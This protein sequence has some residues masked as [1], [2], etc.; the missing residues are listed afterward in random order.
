VLNDFYDVEDDEDEAG[1]RRARKA[2]AN[3]KS[4]GRP[5]KPEPSAKPVKPKGKMGGAR[6]GAGR[7]PSKRKEEARTTTAGGRTA[8]KAGSTGKSQ[9]FEDYYISQDKDLS[10]NGDDDDDDD[11]VNGEVSELESSEEE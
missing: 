10:V 7:K 1:N 2:P 8:G 5:R 9:G 6:P 4:R 11:F 3:D